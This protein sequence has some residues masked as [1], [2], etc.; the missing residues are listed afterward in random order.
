MPKPKIKKILR[1]VVAS[2]KVE[3]YLNSGVMYCKSKLDDIVLIL[4]TSEDGAI[5]I[6]TVMTNHQFEEQKKRLS[7]LRSKQEVSDIDL[8][9]HLG[10]YGGDASVTTHMKL[11]E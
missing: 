7:E 2:N 4:T 1:N 8:L 5:V 6:K 3:P 9:V 11:G 10:N